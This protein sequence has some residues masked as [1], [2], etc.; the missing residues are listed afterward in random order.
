[1]KK[2]ILVLTLSVFVITAGSYAAIFSDDFES[3]TLDKWDIGV[4]QGGRTSVADVV[5]RNN[6][7]MGHIYQDG[8]SKIL[9]SKTFDYRDGL[10]FSF[11]METSVYSEAQDFKG[12][13]YV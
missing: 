13:N 8:L 1:M 4:G 5:T 6:S 3:G 11:D 9:I 7:Q 2:A 10:N 12:F